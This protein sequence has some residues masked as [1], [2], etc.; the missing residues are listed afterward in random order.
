MTHSEMVNLVAT[1]TNIDAKQVSRVIKAVASAVVTEVSNGGN[2]K[3]LGLGRFTRKRLARRKASN[4]K[5]GA[6]IT[7]NAK[8]VPKFVASASFKGSLE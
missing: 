7:V 6:V 1:S 2:A 4:P 8:V 5:T 3:I